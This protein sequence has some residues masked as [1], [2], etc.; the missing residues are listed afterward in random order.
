M[1]RYAVLALM[2]LS[3]AGW[4]EGWQLRPG[5]EGILLWTQAR[6]PSPF[7][8]L[9]LE[10]Q[11]NADPAA[12]LKVL[13]NTARHQE[14]LPR[15][16]EVRLLA[17]SGPDDDLVYTRLSAPWPVHDRELITR[18]HL[19]R[20]ADCGLTLEVW[21]EPNA[22]P[23]QAG[24]FR[25]Q[26]SSGRWEAQ[27]RPDGTTLIRLETYTNPGSNL[28]GWLANPMAIKGALESFQAIRRLMEEQ[29]RVANPQHLL[30]AS[31]RCP[32]LSE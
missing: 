21:A 23:V 5:K 17:K 9:R 19:S 26:E 6:P 20:G 14:W 1:A 32:P 2:L 12:L 10:M 7:L 31:Q 22:L 3:F 25:I 27:P 18:S 15:S 8:A 16:R 13:R 4:G 28:P 30:G 24:R 29:P 11:V